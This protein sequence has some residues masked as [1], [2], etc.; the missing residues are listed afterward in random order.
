MGIEPRQYMT[1]SQP[2]AI[3]EMVSSGFGIGFFPEWAVKSAI[4]S[5]VL[6]A[7]PVTRTGIP[8][9]WNA[10]F[11]KNRQIQVFQREFINMVSKLNPVERADGH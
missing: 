2:Q 6:T 5:K 10:A 9:Q 11:L 3:I 7:L 1:V 8:I 4:D